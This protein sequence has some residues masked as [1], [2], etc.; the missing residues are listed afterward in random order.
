MPLAAWE[1]AEADLLGGKRTIPEIAAA[2]GLSERT[3]RDELRARGALTTAERKPAARRSRTPQANAVVLGAIGETPDAVTGQLF[4]AAR[5]SLADGDLDGAEKVARVARGMASLGA[6]WRKPRGDRTAGGG[7]A[8]SVAAD[9]GDAAPGR[10]ALTLHGP[11]RPPEGAWRTWMFLGGRGAGKTLAGAA[12]LADRACR[13]ARTALV[14]PSLA[15]VWE[16]M[17]EGPSGL[18]TAHAAGW[19]P[20]EGAAPRYEPS[21]RRLAWGNGAVTLAFSAEDPESLRGPQFAAA[22]ADELCVWPRAEI[23]LAN[24]RLGLRLGDDP[25]LV[26]TTTPKPS[27]WLRRLLEEPDLAVTRAATALNAAHLAPGFLEGLE[28]LYGGTRLARQELEGEVLGAVEGA[29]F[30]PEDLARAR[31]LGAAGPPERLDALVVAVD[32]P[33]GDGTAAAEGR[34]A[35]CGV[36][37]AGRLG[38][39]AWVL[40]DRTVRGLG[41]LGWARAVAVAAADWAG[42]GPLRVA[43]EAN[44]GGAMVRTVLD[45]AGLAAPVRLVRAAAGKRQRAEP[46]ALLYEQGLVA[47]VGGLSALEAEL[48]ALGE[49]ALT[50]SPD[51]AD[52]LVWALTELMVGGERG[53]RIRVL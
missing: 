4:E 16:V 43:A 46:V 48:T 34:G 50:A 10:P 44:Q 2:L 39:R 40:D 33:A 42:R 15:D 53:P 17:A 5:R 19:G 24:L 8:G 9:A 23:T 32:P 51:R 41:P 3:V 13:D 38:G 14:G 26:L 11:Q 30:R 47:H 52:A 37:V 7:S 29:L 21:R 35:A 1:E 20:R 25:R 22:W 31:E 12:W 6:A 28:R 27:A 36:V 45:Q 18:I 49:D